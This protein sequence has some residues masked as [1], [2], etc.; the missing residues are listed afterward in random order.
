M[1]KTFKPEFLNRVD[2]TVIYHPLSIKSMEVIVDIQS[3]RIRKLLAEKKIGLTLTDKARKHFAKKGYDPA[4]GARTLKRILQREIQDE[5]ALKI[6][7]G[8]YGEDDD[9]IVDF[10]RGK[11]SL[12]RVHRKHMEEAGSEPE[13]TEQP[14]PA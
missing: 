7:E 1:K 11:V 10:A 12:K 8:E 6:L 3:G 2:D 4:Y 5:L 9:C 14:Q 13:D